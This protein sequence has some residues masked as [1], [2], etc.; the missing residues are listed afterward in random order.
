MLMNTSVLKKWSALRGI[1]VV[2]PRQG[3]KVGVVEDFFFK[4]GTGVVYALLVDTGVEG[5]RSL[6]TSGISAVTDDSVAIFNA[7]ML[8]RALPPLPTGSS[9]LS[10]KVVGESGIEVG[11]VGEVVLDIEPPVI[12]IAALELAEK[13]G[14]RVLGDEVLHYHQGL[15]VIDD[16]DA[17][18]LR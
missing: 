5:M 9:L 7:E 18:R 2:V 13:R 4:A 6:P 15:I 12:R 1:A 16:Q 11:T 3:R 10:Y 14:K 17:R 8:I